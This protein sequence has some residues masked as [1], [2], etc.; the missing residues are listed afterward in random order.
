MWFNF[1]V[2]FLFKNF[3]EIIYNY[4]NIFFFSVRSGKI[5]VLLFKVGIFLLCNG[6]FDDKYKCK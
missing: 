1:L 3:V 2:F 4:V 6:Y 5:R